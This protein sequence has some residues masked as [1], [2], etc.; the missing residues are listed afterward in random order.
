MLNLSRLRLR[1]S[2]S[3]SFILITLLGTLCW[4]TRPAYAH[5]PHD[6]TV[7]VAI[8]PNF[9]QD[10][11]VFATTDLLSVTLGVRIMLRSHDGGLTWEVVPNFPNVKVNNLRFS[12]SYATDSTLF[13]STDNGLYR[14]TNGGD[15]WTDLA[16]AMGAASVA[17]ALSPYFDLDQTLFALSPVG[18]LYRSTDAGDSWTLI[19]IGN[20]GKHLGH[21]GHDHGEMAAEVAYT[22]TN[23][24]RWQ[25]LPEFNGPITPLF[26]GIPSANADYELGHSHAEG[27][28]VLDVVPRNTI[29]FSPNFPLDQTIFVGLAGQG[30]FKSTNGGTTWVPI[31]GEMAGYDITTLVVSPGYL[32]TQTVYASTYG[33]GIFVSTNGGTTWTARNS[34]INDLETIS[35]V[36][37]PTFLTD[38]TAFVSTAVGELYTST[39]RGLT[40]SALSGPPRE[41]SEQTNVHYRRLGISP[42]FKNDH[43]LF[44]PTFEGMWKSNTAGTTWRY[45]EILPTSL[46]RSLS[47]SPAYGQDTTV[48]ASTY[49]GGMVRTQDAA[50]TWVP[51]TT[52]MLNGYPDPTAISASYATSPVVFVG[53]VWGPQRT[54]NGGASWTFNPV[55]NTPVFARAVAL[56]PEFSGDYTLAVGVDNLE[57]GHPPYVVWNGHVVSTNGVFISR[58]A[59]NSWVPTQ[60]NG[61][62]VQSVAF[63]P[64]FGADQVIYA[65]SLYYGLYRSVNGGVNWTRLGTFPTECCV[66]RVVLSPSY[67]G[68][69]TVFISRP[70]GEPV[71]RGLYKSVNNGSSWQR[72]LGSEDVTLLDFVLSPDF[73]NDGVLYVATLEKGVLKSTDGGATLFQTNLT[74]AYVTALDISAN[75]ANDETVY[76]ATYTGIYR[77][78]DGGSSWTQTIYRTRVEEDRASITPMG[79]WSVISVANSSAG[80]VLYS[81]VPGDSLRFDYAGTNV[82]LIGGKGSNFG[83]IDVYLDGVFMQ[84]VD[85]Y[86]PTS[87]QQ[88]ILFQSNGV[89]FGEHTLSL[90]ISA[91]KN[92]A[93]TGHRTTIDAFDVWR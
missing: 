82:A 62:G 38:R 58:S 93:S 21:A 7:N 71:A 9:A 63:S 35:I 91:D 72:A 14:S 50:Q 17:V 84:T 61:V 39:D 60:L 47:V 3:I 29:A 32:V 68:D 90:V 80:F 78:E 55:L 56:S 16:P 49:G 64:N 66:S 92:P 11:T 70:T 46:V 81:E 42:N 19:P 74:D 4:P 36:L 33:G 27:P 51:L 2:V 34:G 18:D 54:L 28:L 13:A 30:L 12:P 5:Q 73:A 83:I 37:S 57:T 44:L 76:A 25:L 48:F 75:Y 31:G 43:I 15:T 85:L 89:P 52:G 41:L 59:G 1:T 22:P 79:S 87:L 67:A 86:S 65:S 6:D 77:S 20:D 40:W 10:Q 26:A 24:V 23:N 88:Q 8:S 69:Q 53:T 45:S